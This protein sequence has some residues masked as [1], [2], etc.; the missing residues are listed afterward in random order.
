MQGWISVT[1][2]A[3][4]LGVATQYFITMCRRWSIP[5]KGADQ[6]KKYVSKYDLETFKEFTLLGLESR[7]SKRNTEMLRIIMFRLAKLERQMND[8]YETILGA[9]EKLSD[10]RQAIIDVVGACLAVCKREKLAY[11]EQELMKWAKFFIAIDEGY[12]LAVDRAKLGT[13]ATELFKKTISV[14][15]GTEADVDLN[16]NPHLA[17][18]YGLLKV[19]ERNLNSAT[20]SYLKEMASIKE[21]KKNGTDAI[22]RIENLMLSS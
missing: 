1:Q 6:A 12:L 14:L 17:V 15:K 9:N 20:D 13:P 21:Y 16:R 3:E 5:I 10:N 4:E 11:S 19:S 18:A 2:A 8:V 22:G 7:S